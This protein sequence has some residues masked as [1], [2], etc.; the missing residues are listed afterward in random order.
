MLALNTHDPHE[1]SSAAAACAWS[2]LAGARRG[3]L[4]GALP[5]AAAAAR[6]RR[7]DPLPSRRTPTLEMRSRRTEG[8]KRD[9]R[10]GACL[11]AAALPADA[12]LMLAVE[13]SP[14]TTR[15]GSRSLAAAS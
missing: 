3:C 1:C 4:G 5:E 11:A 13:M 8:S 10:G 12:L 2:V 15:T 9:L 14:A 6:A 7:A